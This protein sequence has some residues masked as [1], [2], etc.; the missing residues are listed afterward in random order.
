MGKAGQRRPRLRRQALGR[1]NPCLH[2]REASLPV[3]GPVEQEE[4][5]DQR[6][7]HHTRPGQHRHP[8]PLQPFRSRALPLAVFADDAGQQVVCEL[9]ALRA[10]LRLD[11]QQPPVDQRREL[12]LRHAVRSPRIVH[13][14][15][16]RKPLSVISS[17]SMNAARGPASRRPTPRRSPR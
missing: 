15:G 4:H 16:L 7:Q 11:P 5:N 1:R 13:V 9:D 17:F 12:L 14:A 6:S 2:L 8:P 10:V 3:C